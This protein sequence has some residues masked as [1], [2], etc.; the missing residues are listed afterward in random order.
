MYE[1]ILLP[2]DGREESTDIIQHASEI[3]RQTEATIHVLFVAD[4]TRDSVTVVDNRVV[5]ALVQQGE[6]IVADAR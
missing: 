6:D 4:T 5:D 2:V 3:G 1:N